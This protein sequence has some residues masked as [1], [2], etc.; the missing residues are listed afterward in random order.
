[1]GEV[2]QLVA[3][4]AFSLQAAGR[5]VSTIFAPWVQDLALLVE[6][7]EVVRPAGALPDWQPGAVVRMPF[8][9]KICNDGQAVSSQAL[10]ALA[11]SAMVIGC[12]ERL[13]ADEHDRP[14]HAFPTAGDVRRCRRRARGADR[15]QHQLWP[16][17]AARRRR[18]APGRHGRQ[19]LFNAVIRLSRTI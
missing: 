6:S 2:H 16:R 15:A 1:M 7:V 5:L 19:R 4:E 12:V 9:K 10:M 3:N 11:D 8:S 17:H 13:S 18:Q 14:D